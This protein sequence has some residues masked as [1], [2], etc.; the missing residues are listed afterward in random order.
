MSNIVCISI[1]IIALSGFLCSRLS[2]VRFEHFTGTIV[3]A[4][5]F[6]E[7]IP[8]FISISLCVHAM[9]PCA[10]SARRD[11][12]RFSRHVARRSSSFETMHSNYY[13]EASRIRL[14]CRFSG[15]GGAQRIRFRWE[16][17]ERSENPRSGRRGASVCAVRSN[18]E[19]F[20]EEYIVDAEDNKR[21]SK[22]K[23]F[24]LTEAFI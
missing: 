22:I 10:R 8:F 16:S 1:Q 17:N 20:N 6:S 19:R 7:S 14:I 5:I 3:S 11:E 12:R 21:F 18:S 15:V 2:P 4:S 9:I 24:N 13:C 23:L